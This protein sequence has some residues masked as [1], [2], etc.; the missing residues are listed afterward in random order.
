MTLDNTYSY[1]KSK[2]VRYHLEV[3]DNPEMSKNDGPPPGDD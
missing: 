1:L 2:V 3:V